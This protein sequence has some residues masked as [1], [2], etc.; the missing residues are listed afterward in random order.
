MQHID[1]E[2]WRHIRLPGSTYLSLRHFDSRVRDP[3]ALI[4]LFFFFKFLYLYP[5]AT[6]S[7]VPVILTQKTKRTA[8]SNTARAAARIASDVGSSLDTSA[9]VLKKTVTRTPRKAG[10]HAPDDAQ[11]SG[12]VKA[13]GEGKNADERTERERIAAMVDAEMKFQRKAVKAIE[14]LEKP[15]ATKNI[16]ATEGPSN[17]IPGDGKGEPTTAKTKQYCRTAPYAPPNPNPKAAP[18][19]KPTLTPKRNTLT[20]KQNERAKAKWEAYLRTVR[21]CEE[22]Q[23]RIISADAEGIFMAPHVYDREMKTWHYFRRKVEDVEKGGRLM[24]DEDDED[25]DDDDEDEDEDED[26]DDE[27]EDDEEDDE[28]D[29]EDEDDEEDE[30]DDEDDDDDEYDGRNGYRRRR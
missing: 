17:E 6:P 20:P 30:D 25:D 19:P 23:R 2:R 22:S 28:D 29:D 8:E 26:E 21:N 3:I 16:V 15:R 4:V 13:R 9:S 12:T 1:S 24:D 11:P 5:S 7:R 14:T 27:D 18:K 10:S